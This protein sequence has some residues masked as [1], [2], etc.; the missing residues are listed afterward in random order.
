MFSNH[1]RWCPQNMTNADKG[2]AAIS[3]AAFKRSNEQRGEASE[4][5]VVCGACSQQFVVIEPAKQHPKRARYFCSRR[6]ANSRGPRSSEVKEKIRFALTLPKANVECKLET[7]TVAFTPRKRSHVFCSRSCANAGRKTKSADT[8]RAYRAA[9]S[10]RFAL[11]EF[12]DEFDFALVEQLGWYSAAN[13]GGNLGGVSRD[14]IVSVKFGFEHGVDPTVIAHPANC[15][16]I[17]Q[18]ENASKHSRSSLTLEEL[19]QRIV[20]WNERHRQAA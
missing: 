6:C 12:P 10:F 17:A 13:H 7:C 3:V 20:E 9:A 14:H 5:T 15:R 2:C 8:L 1:T 19:Q 11:N 16:L 18:N 4:F